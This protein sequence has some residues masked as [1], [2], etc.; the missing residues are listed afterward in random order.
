MIE[1]EYVA[2]CYPCA[3]GLTSECLDAELNEDGLIVP[4]I[5]RYRPSES[6]RAGSAA[7]D[8][9]NI[10][11][12][13]ST[14]RKRAAMIAPIT[15]GMLCEWQGLRQAGGGVVPIVGCAGS[16]L[17]DQKGGEPEHGLTQGDR[18]HGPDKSTINNAP[19]TNL[20]RICVTCHH[21]W[22]AVNDPFYNGTRPSAAEPY[23]PLE[24]YFSHDPNTEATLEEQEAAEEWWQLPKKSRPAYP[25]KP[26]GLRR[27]D[28]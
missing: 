19:G 7:L 21:R 15:R 4:C 23:L 13:T 6:A 11:D 5:V 12:P 10:T 8:P 3:Q 17:S 16:L 1:I 9:S 26:E 14:G 22:H 24:P 20:H 28:T 18:H 27:I 25:V 2:A